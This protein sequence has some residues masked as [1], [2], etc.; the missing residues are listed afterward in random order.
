[1]IIGSSPL[2][3]IRRRGAREESAIAL[4]LAAAITRAGNL[5][6][7]EQASGVAEGSQNVDQVYRDVLTQLAK[8]RIEPDKNQTFEAVSDALI[9]LSQRTKTFAEFGLTPITRVEP[10]IELLASMDRSRQELARHILGLYIES[11]NTRLNSLQDTQELIS[12]FVSNIQR[13]F[14]P[15][16]RITFSLRD[17]LRIRDPGSTYLQPEQLSSG[18]RHLLLLLC[19]ALIARRSTSLFLIDEPELSLNASWQR[20][21]VRSLLEI[22]SGANVQFIMATHSIQIISQ[23]EQY[24][25]RLR[26]GSK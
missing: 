13:Y 9:S 10:L 4:E 14:G 21:L 6:R 1:M 7:R 26:R 18:E 2:A 16:K 19:N 20:H 5:I 12:K 17:G 22:T 15:E 25:A 8:E 11:Q 3:Q 23:Y 24:L